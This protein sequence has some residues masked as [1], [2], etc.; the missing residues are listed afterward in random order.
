MVGNDPMNQCDYLGLTGVGQILQQFFRVYGG[1]EKLWVMDEQDQYTKRVRSWAPVI[2][3]MQMVRNAV[4]SSSQTWRW[5]HT[6]TPGWRPSMGYH[7]D[8]RA[9][10]NRLVPSPPGTDPGAARNHLLIFLATN[11]ETDE[12]HFSSIGSF[13]I[14]ATVD[15]IVGCQATVD[16]W[17]YNEM[18]RRS[19]GRFAN[20]VPFRWSSMDS[21]YM[22]WNWKEK[23]E[24]D[25]SGRVTKI[26]R[27]S[28]Q[29]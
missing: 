19:F 25:S 16:I 7:P 10:Y 26:T 8:P 17:M 22:W 27:N 24:F 18:S 3:Q 2:Q 1:G 15:K 5:R 9:G 23:F 21:Q 20:Q 11:I 4:A 12:L 29:W 28:S 13:R 6:T 14:I